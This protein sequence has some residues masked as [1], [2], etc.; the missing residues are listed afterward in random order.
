MDRGRLSQ[1]D[2]LTRGT[3]ACVFGFFNPVKKFFFCD[4]QIDAVSEIKEM[5][6]RLLK[7][8]PER[9]RPPKNDSGGSQ[10]S[11]NL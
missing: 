7:V 3:D 10:V 5:L 8:Y 1:S 11:L 2:R 4:L 6:E 9:Q